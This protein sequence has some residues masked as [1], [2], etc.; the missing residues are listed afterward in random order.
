MH[1]FAAVVEFGSGNSTLWW[2]EK[3]AS[4]V[5]V[6]HDPAWYDRIEA[7]APSNVSIIHATGQDYTRGAN[8]GKFDII[9]V[10]GILRT[11]CIE[12]SLAALKSDGVYVCDNTDEIGD[13][14][15]YDLLHQA[16]FKRLDFWGVGPQLPLEWCTSIFY[17]PNNILG[18]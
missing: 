14:P 7:L 10:D 18:I 9:V 2:A 11:E 12:H 8:G 13:R 5:T 6:E 16:G 3:V 1:P 4:V 17:R 15:G